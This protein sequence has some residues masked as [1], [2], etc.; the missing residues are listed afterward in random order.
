M[1]QEDGLTGEAFMQA[2]SNIESDRDD[3]VKEM[4]QYKQSYTKEELFDK[5]LHDTDNK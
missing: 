5:I 3:I 4:S 1:I 2:L